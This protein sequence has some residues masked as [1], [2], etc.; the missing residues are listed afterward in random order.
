MAASSKKS[1]GML[2]YRFTA[3]E[4]EVLLVHPGG[5][6]WSKKD[7]ASW[8]IP[9]GELGDTEEPLVAAQRELEEETGIKAAGSFIT[10]TPVKQKSGKLVYA[11]ALEKDVNVA[12]IKSNELQMEWPPRSGKMKSF[13]EID[14]AGWFKVAEAKVKIIPGQSPLIDE[15][16]RLLKK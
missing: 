7:A 3:G 5:P 13:P 8:S 10:L 11:F 14:K 2:L 1:A 9:K 16:A 12:S 6:F 4:M 15:L